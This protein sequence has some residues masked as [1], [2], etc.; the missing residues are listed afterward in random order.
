M[1]CE[2]PHERPKAPPRLPSYLKKRPVPPGYAAP[3]HT[4]P[5]CRPAPKKRTNYDE[6]FGCL[7]IIFLCAG[8]FSLGYSLSRRGEAS[9]PPQAADDTIR[10][11]PARASASGL[12]MLRI[13]PDNNPAE[14][15]KRGWMPSCSGSARRK[16]PPQQPFWISR[17]AITQWQWEQVMGTRPWRNKPGYMEAPDRTAGNISREEGA[18]FCRRLSEATS[19]VWR[20]PSAAEYEYAKKAGINPGFHIVLEKNEAAA[21]GLFEFSGHPGQDEWNAREAG[22]NCFKYQHPLFSSAH[23]EP[24]SAIAVSP[25][26]AYL[27][28]TS[29][30][31]T[32]KI[33]SISGAEKLSEH[34]LGNM[35]WHAMALSPGAR[36]AAFGAPFKL[37]EQ[38][39]VS[40][41]AINAV[42]VL[43]LQEN[44]LALEIDLVLRA[45]AFSP[46]GRHFA[47]LDERNLALY[48]TE[49]WKLL[50]TLEILEESQPRLSCP[51]IGFNPEA[52]E[53]TVV[54]L[55]LRVTFHIDQGTLLRRAAFDTPRKAQHLAAL[56]EAPFLLACG[57]RDEAGC[58][59]F[60]ADQIQSFPY[61]PPPLKGPMLFTP[62][63]A[64][65]AAADMRGWIDVMTVPFF[66]RV[67][68]FPVLAE[69]LAATQDG[70]CLIAHDKY[71]VFMFPIT[72]VD[73]PRY[74]KDD[75]DFSQYMEEQFDQDDDE[76]KDQDAQY[77]MK[78]SKA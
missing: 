35:I 18:E 17:L 71:H 75:F 76:E 69:A 65:M 64:Y 60:G 25:D 21:G 26:G 57:E 52:T 23:R 73:A 19:G 54:D 20:F 37:L 39:S 70:K 45:F 34:S 67:K 44:A 2:R 11:R 53:V 77:G 49:S 30:D 24:I 78:K 42:H 47:V 61:T 36:Y 59:R 32:V 14:S 68:R 28:S 55:G 27:A 1:N 72:G 10:A 6:L 3:G 16:A 9:A 62:G 50:R 4:A 29:W 38:F 48:D 66:T 22:N 5:P 15:A 31:S 56:P 33:W 41:V 40:P 13:Q 46:G 43:D 12:E 63:G 51:A 58:W 7:F 8:F 74:F